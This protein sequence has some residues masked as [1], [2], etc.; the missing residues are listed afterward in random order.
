MQ[1]A[2]MNIPGVD[3]GLLH[4]V[5]QRMA[6]FVS[7]DSPAGLFRKPLVGMAAV[8][9]IFQ[10][11]E[12]KVEA[13]ERLQD[14]HVQDLAIFNYLL[15]VE[16]WKRRDELTEHVLSESRRHPA[17]LQHP[18]VPRRRPLML[19]SGKLPKISKVSSLL[20]PATLGR[21]TVDG[22]RNVLSIARRG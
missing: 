19:L 4:L 11:I 18:A 2:M 5:K 3:S 21:G 6:F 14:G 13:K 1:R 20:V 15:S 12:A 16:Q 17:L 9:A 10:K 22:K 8:E 7:L